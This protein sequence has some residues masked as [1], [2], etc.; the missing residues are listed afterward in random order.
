[1]RS[2]AVFRRLAI[3]NLERSASAL[4]LYTYVCIQYDIRLYAI[5]A[6]R[7]V[8]DLVKKSLWGGSSTWS[9]WYACGMQVKRLA[10]KRACHVRV[11]VTVLRFWYAFGMRVKLQFSCQ[12]VQGLAGCRSCVLCAGRGLRAFQGRP[13]GH[14]RQ[15]WQ[16]SSP[17]IQPRSEPQKPLNTKESFRFVFWWLILPADRPGGAGGLG[18]WAGTRPAGPRAGRR[19]G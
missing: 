12:R 13:A 6:D 14:W 19:A 16:D 18:S 5:Y 9:F 17:G 1:M 10:E 7:H 11:N 8:Y 4:C 15:I 2:W 3:R